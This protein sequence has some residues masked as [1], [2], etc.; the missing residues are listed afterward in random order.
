MNLPPHRRNLG[1]G[2]TGKDPV[3][4]ID[5]GDLGD[6]L[7]YAPETSGHGFIEPGGPMSLTEYQQALA[8]TAPPWA[9]LP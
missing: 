4:S 5:S 2:G 7:G 9:R 6:K 8:A 1:H 3:W